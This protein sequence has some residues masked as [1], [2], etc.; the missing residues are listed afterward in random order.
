MGH[1]ASERSRRNGSGGSLVY[2]R[3]FPSMG[4]VMV[5][6]GSLLALLAS[7]AGLLTL[8]S[9][10]ILSDAWAVAFAISLFTLICAMEAR[11]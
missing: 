10:H 9:T 6:W 1:C 2:R 7:V 5:L 3:S 8:G 4:L 11:T